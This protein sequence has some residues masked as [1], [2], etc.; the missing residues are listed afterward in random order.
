MWKDLTH[1]LLQKYW[2][3]IGYKK[4]TI[5]GSAFLDDLPTVFGNTDSTGTF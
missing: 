4:I 3:N 5:I 2:S 1:Q